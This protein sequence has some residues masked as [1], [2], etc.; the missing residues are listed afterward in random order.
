MRDCRCAW[1]RDALAADRARWSRQQRRPVRRAALRGSRDGAR[2]TRRALNLSAFV[3]GL[4]VVYAA[5][6]LGAGL[7]SLVTRN[8]TVLNAVLRA[9]SWRPD[10]RRCCARE[11][12]NT[13]IMRSPLR[14]AFERSVLAR[15]RFR[16]GRLAVL[17][18][19]ARRRRRIPRTRRVCGRA[20]RAARIFALGHAAPVV[21]LAASTV[22]ARH[23][24]G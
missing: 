11:P 7:L 20:R 2:R 24:H 6:G 9:L 10:W 5:L 22:F 18:A 23:L 15:R 17:Y 21:L 3:A 14:H 8:A 19:D 16:A 4:V 1:R 12:A 13:R